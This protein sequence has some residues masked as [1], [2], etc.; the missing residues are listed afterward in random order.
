MFVRFWKSFVAA[1]GSKLGKF[2]TKSGKTWEIFFSN[3]CKNPVLDSFYAC[4]CN[5]QIQDRS[6]QFG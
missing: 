6:L 4:G 5:R 3:L 2:G 1:Y